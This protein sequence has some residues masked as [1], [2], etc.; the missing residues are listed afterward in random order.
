M[1]RSDAALS[2]RGYFQ[3]LLSWADAVDAVV[4]QGLKGAVGWG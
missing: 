4:V 1:L 2:L 3:S